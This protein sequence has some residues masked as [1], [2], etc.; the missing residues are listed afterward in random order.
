MRE[1]QTYVA[2]PHPITLKVFDDGV[3]RYYIA[4]IPMLKGC[5]SDGITIQEALKNVLEAKQGWVSIKLEYHEDIPIPEN[6]IPI[7]ELLG[8]YTE[9]EINEMNVTIEK[10]TEL[11]R[12]INKESSNVIYLYKDM[13]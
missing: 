2:M 3:E 5:K 6:K 12:E 9:K 7:I 1:E 8:K 4:N 10:F 13:E 11:V